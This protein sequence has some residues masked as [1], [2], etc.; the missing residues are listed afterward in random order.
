MESL[1][2]LFLT[3]VPYQNYIRCGGK[4]GDRLAFKRKMLHPQFAMNVNHV[5]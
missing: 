4:T 1:S 2:N 5:P 3:E